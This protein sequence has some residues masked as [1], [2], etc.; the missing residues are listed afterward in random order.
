ML[1]EVQ[2]INMIYVR[3]TECH[4]FNRL[5]KPAVLHILSEKGK[6]EQDDWHPAVKQATKFPSAR[7]LLFKYQ[8]PP[9]SYGL[10]EKIGKIITLLLHVTSDLMKNEHAS[11]NGPL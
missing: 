2:N 8:P 4:R 11:S 7:S 10:R 3:M 9:L 6:K 1:N 5:M